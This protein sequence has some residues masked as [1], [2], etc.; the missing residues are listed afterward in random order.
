[1]AK[2]LLP[3]APKRLAADAGESVVGSPPPSLS[4]KERGLDGLVSGRMEC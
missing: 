2:D 3:S 4:Q 1:M